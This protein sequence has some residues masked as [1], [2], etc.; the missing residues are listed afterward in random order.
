M[1]IPSFQDCLLP[2]LTHVG[3]GEEWRDVKIRKAM[4][5]HFGLTDEEIT[6]LLPS[7]G[8][9]RIDNRLGWAKFYLKKA[10]LVKYPQRGC[11]QI[12]A[13]GKELLESPPEKLTI[14]Y[15]A[16]N[17]P[18]AFA[19][20]NAAPGLEQGE[21]A[22]RANEV[23][24]EVD[25]TERLDSAFREIC[26]SVADELLEAVKS[27][28]SRFL[29]QA[30][31]DLMRAMGYGEAHVT[32]RGK[33]G[34]IDGIVNEDELG[35]DVVYLQAKNWK[36]VVGR[37]DVETFMGAV[38]AQGGN[39]GV[40]ITTSDF[41]REAKEMADKSRA[42]VKVRLINGAEP[43]ELMFEHGVGVVVSKKLEIKKVDGNYFDATL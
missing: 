43:A 30:A 24:Q 16:E 10:G 5:E 7:G 40:L 19:T 26:A 11:V 39:R 38:D 1:A 6:D 8:Q 4:Y 15:L 35:L 14:R 34:G 18:A 23:E 37:P 12:T 25:S 13:V 2:Y 9:T 29:E 33:D 31:A 17:Y 32:S 28:G 21:A 22:G 3:D 42:K 20:G 41:S 27:A 36:N